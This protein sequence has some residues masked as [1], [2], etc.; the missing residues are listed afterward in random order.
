MTAQPDTGQDAVLL[1]VVEGVGV[2]T[3]NRPDRLNAVDLPMME[4]LLARLDEAADRA[5]VRVLVLTGAGR[6]FCAGADLAVLDELGAGAREVAMPGMDYLKARTIGKPVIAAINGPCAGLGLILA[7]TC[8]LRFSTPTARFGSG[9]ARL[10]LVAEQ[11]LAWLLP[12]VVGTG[13]AL[14]V[15][16]TARLFDGAEALDMGLVDRVHPADELLAQTLDYARGIAAT[17]SPVSLAVIKWQVQRGAETSL[18]QAMEDADPLTRRSLTGHD[19]VAVGSRLKAGDVPSYPPL[20]R[21]AR[22][23]SEPPVDLIGEAHR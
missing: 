1:D 15:L 2:I 19:F 13:K 11:G 20:A 23:G 3:L 17:S 22:L 6:G 5:D 18:E 10:G 4:A 16:F 21:G 12:R 14:D 7:L 8:D 9:F